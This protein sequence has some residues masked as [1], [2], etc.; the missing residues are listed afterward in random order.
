MMKRAEEDT[1]EIASLRIR[2]QELES[3]RGLGTGDVSRRACARLR[4]L[5]RC[6]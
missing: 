5:L 3:Q 4:E 2:C 6:P 1:S